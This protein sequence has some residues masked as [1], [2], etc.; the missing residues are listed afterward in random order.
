MKNKKIVIKTLLQNI[1]EVTGG[2]GC[3]SVIEASGNPEAVKL[4]LK[5]ASVRGKIIIVGCPHG[6]VPLDLYTDLQRKEIS[7][8]G[9]YFPRCP[10]DG[11]LRYPWT[12]MG[13]RQLIID[14]LARSR[15][16]F[17]SLVTHRSRFSEIPELYRI[18]SEE[19]NKSITAVIDW[20]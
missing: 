8:S 9:S 6:V 19:K 17:S 11:N 2:K 20:N 7:V 12:Y 14:F 18:L 15:L 10:A 3:E 1:G 5:A 16:D 4:A 13:N